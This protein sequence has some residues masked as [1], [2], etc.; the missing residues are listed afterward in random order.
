MERI[1]DETRAKF[2]KKWRNY[3]EGRVQVDLAKR[4]YKKAPHCFLEANGNNCY[5]D[6]NDVHI[7]LKGLPSNDEDELFCDTVFATGHEAG[8]FKFSRLDA[9][10]FAEDEIFKKVCQHGAS[11]VGWKGRFVKEDNSFPSDI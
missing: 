2:A 1:S 6:Y 3:F 11:L 5:M 4:M 7:G 8:H 9:K 10:L